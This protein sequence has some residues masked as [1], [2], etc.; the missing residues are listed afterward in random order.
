MK[1]GRSAALLIS[2]SV[3]AAVILAG[4]L[5]D[6]NFGS[7][8]ARH[9]AEQE[10]N[11]YISIKYPD[12]VT[13]SDIQYSRAGGA[14][15]VQASSVSSTDIYCT[16]SWKDGEI[17]DGY[18]V[19]VEN[20]GNTLNRLSAQ[21]GEYMLA[22]RSSAILS[23]SDLSIC[24]VTVVL[25][26]RSKRDIPPTVFLDVPFSSDMTVFEGC[27]ITYEVT[28][29]ASLEEC[30]ALLESAFEQDAALPWSAGEYEIYGT[31]GEE[32]LSISIEGVTGA[33]IESGS[34]SKLLYAAQSGQAIS[35]SPADMPSDG[36]DRFGEKVAL[37]SSDEITVSISKRKK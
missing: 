33:H 34:L 10:L 32:N 25:S 12:M 9:R 6:L 19:R 15:I 18:A 37:L 17:S 8:V 14:Y 22:E 31:D 29:D 30:A 5:L 24:S 16:L 4:V 35:V 20:L 1:M 3:I 13:S 23:A 21:M 28:A 26:P 36:I 11:E 7:P 27:K 2:V